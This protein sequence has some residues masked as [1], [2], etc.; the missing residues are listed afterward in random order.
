[1]AD[2]FYAGERNPVI[3]YLE[4]QGWEVGSQARAELFAAYGRP[5]PRPT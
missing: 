4:G 5:F 3:G 2:L 1:M